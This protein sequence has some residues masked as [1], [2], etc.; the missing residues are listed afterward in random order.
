[1]IKKN[2][3]CGYVAIIGRSNTGKSTLINQL[4]KKKISITSKKL[5]TT[6]NKILG[7]YTE[8]LYQIIY[9]DTPGIYQKSNREINR[10]MNNTINDVINNVDLIIFMIESTFWY[11]EDEIIINKLHN[12]NC[13]VILAINKIDC[14][15]E[16][17]K[18]S[19]T[20][21]IC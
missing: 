5:H 15:S 8:G 18:Y 17:K 21:K 20:N 14:I 3:Y 9:I 7:V 16:K 13:P 11:L 10:F 1:M 19:S 4:I 6:R 2:T 12:I